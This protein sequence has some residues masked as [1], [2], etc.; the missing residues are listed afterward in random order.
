[1]NN[2]EY[3]VSVYV[4]KPS[5]RL[6]TGKLRP[7]LTFTTYSTVVEDRIARVIMPALKLACQEIKDGFEV[8]FS[9]D[10]DYGC[11][12]LK[13]GAKQKGS[14]RHQKIGKRK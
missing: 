3:S 14:D 5:L 7:M 11:C 2:N 13:Q 6:N 4:N 10:M 8:H 12:I 9:L 1:M